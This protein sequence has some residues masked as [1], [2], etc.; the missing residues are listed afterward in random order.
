MYDLPDEIEVSAE[1]PL[2]IIRLNR[3]DA[4]NAVDDDLHTGLAALWPRLNEDRDA[5][6]AVLTG[7][8]RAFSAGGDFGYLEQLRKDGDLRARSL[9]HGRD[10]VLGM[11]RCRVPV[12]AAVNGPAVGLGCSLVSLSD[13]VYIAERAYLADP[14]VRIGLVAA[15]GGPLT[16]NLHTSMLIAK[17]YALTGDRIPAERAV[18]L[19]LANHVAADPVAEARACAERM[20]ALPRQAVESTKRLFNMQLEKKVLESLDYA[21]AAEER[22]FLT[23]DF[24]AKLA[25][26]GKGGA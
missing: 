3:P 14:H 12:I 22:S 16:W 26:L 2:R 21:N 20:A 23:D 17:E 1:G 19:G 9:A 13:V 7:N 15:D 24:A 5:R 18:E 4:L 6:A 10:I 8:G 25:E 11:A